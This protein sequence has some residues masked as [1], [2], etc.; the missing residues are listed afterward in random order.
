MKPRRD[1]SGFNIISFLEDYEIYHRLSGENVGQGWVGF[2]CPWCSGEKEHG[3][4][5]LTSKSFSCWQCGEK[6]SPSK[7]IKQILDCS[8]GFAYQTVDDYS[9]RDKNRR[10]RASPERRKAKGV[11]VSL[12]LSTSPLEGPGASYLRNRGFDP[13]I[14]K[15]KYKLQETGPLSDYKYRIIIPIYID[16]ELVSFTSRD[17]TGENT[18]KYRAQLIED[19]VI[20]VKEGIYNIDT[21]KDK[22]LIVEGPADVWRMGDESIALYGLNC[23]NGQLEMLLRKK[24]KK[25]VLLLDPKTR[26][27]ADKL[28]FKLIPFIRDIKIVELY[29][30]DPAELT[31]EEALNLRVQ[32]F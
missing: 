3:G 6:A 21:V 1:Y 22:A 10:H 32:I 23:S 13:E 31:D 9:E 29:D 17:Y 26:K 7:L 14:L 8:W 16:K 11:S 25:V 20:P 19:S 18:L 15:S 24:I 27:Q 4:V 28:Y 12:P 5:N 30:Q 2:R